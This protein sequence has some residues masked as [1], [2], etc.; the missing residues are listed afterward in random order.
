MPVV[1]FPSIPY[2]TSNIRAL[3]NSLTREER[4]EGRWWYP[5]QT[6]QLC[7][8]ARVNGQLTRTAL[9]TA[10]IFSPGVRWE[11]AVRE[12]EN[13]L[14]A[15]M[16][17]EDPFKSVSKAIRRANVKR[18]LLALEPAFRFELPRARASRGKKTQAFYD[19]LCGST[20]AVV[21]DRHTLAIALGRVATHA[22]AHALGNYAKPYDSVVLAYELVTLPRPYDVR[23]L[24]AAT[25]LKWRA[26][27]Q[28]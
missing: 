21:V 4:E 7:D 17:G 10:A 2:M 18:A 1:T 8:I 9:A 15:L 22:E 14:R 12:T 6:N 23:S 5:R 13:F 28:K 11:I 3:W 26:K 27:E 20:G 24:Q 16:L 25:W 19:A